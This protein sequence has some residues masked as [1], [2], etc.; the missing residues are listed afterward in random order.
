MDE[1]DDFLKGEIV[2]P[3]VETVE[4]PEVEVEAETPAQ[5]RGP[6][7]KFLPKGDENP[8]TPEVVSPTT[9][10]PKLEHPALIGERRRRQ[11]AETRAKELEAQLQ[12]FQNPPQ[13]A[14][15]MWD[16]EQAWQ[17]HFSQQVTQNATQFASLN[18]KLETSE[19]LAAQ[20]FDDFDAM[21]PKILEFMDTNPA[22]RPDILADRHP[23][24]KAY[25]MVKNN[26]QAKALGATDVDSLRASIRA[27][28][29]A[30]LKAP[31][32]PP[33][34]DTLANAQSARSS[35]ADA[36]PTPPSL[37]Q[38]LGRAAA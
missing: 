10:E 4:T 37:D 31:P 26:E 32:P 33:I 18:A 34:P 6:D 8:E 22:L 25:R 9:E 36:L 27:E 7:G 13:P 2:E 11:E 29:E 1:M 14:P 20:A 28:L 12:Q 24:A 16:D 17:Q 3:T 19:M 15:S 23:W 5:P 38:I 35:S 30:E 21:H